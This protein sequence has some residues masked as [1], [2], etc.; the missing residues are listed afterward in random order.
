VSA[1][2]T[3]AWVRRRLPTQVGW[4]RRRLDP[5]AQGGLPLT[6]AVAA[7]ALFAWIFGGLTQ[8]VAAGEGAATLDP[9]THAFAV[10]HRTGWLTVI[11]RTITWLGSNWVLVPL[12]LAV[13]VVLLRRHGRPA[14]G[15]LWAGYLGAIGLYAIAKQVVSRPRPA[16]IDLIGHVSGSSYPS[17]H[18][19]QSLTAWGMLALLAGTGRSP[20]LRGGLLAAAALVVLLVGVSRIYLGA[21]WLTDVLAGYALGAAWIAALYALRLRRGDPS[22][23][24]TPTRAA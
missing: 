13:T 15:W 12:L 21:H 2:A 7:A 10:A 6:G 3:A 9:G 1:R 18:A 20:R 24:T 11:M 19:I 16:M 22:R 8:D 23:R 5:T 17:G 14:A 4:L